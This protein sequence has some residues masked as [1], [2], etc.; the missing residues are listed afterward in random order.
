[1][2]E[3]DAHNDSRWLDVKTARTGR[4]C[5]ANPGE[6]H[7]SAVT[8]LNDCSSPIEKLPFPSGSRFDHSSQVKRLMRMWT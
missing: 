5:L 6:D 4:L 2:S 8:M 3:V 7:A 1:M